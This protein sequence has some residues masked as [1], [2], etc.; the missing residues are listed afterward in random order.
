MT[1]TARTITEAKLAIK[2]LKLRKKELS[3]LKRQVTE[4]ERAIRAEYTHSVRQRGSKLQGGGGIGRFIRVVQ[5][6][7]RDSA[8]RNLAN[9]LAPY[10]QEKRKIDA[11][12]TAIEEVLLKVEMAI[13]ENSR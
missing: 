13:L 1:V 7:S 3:L 12:T 5:T 11:M 9:R 6:A 4:Q 8:R 2:E 10:E